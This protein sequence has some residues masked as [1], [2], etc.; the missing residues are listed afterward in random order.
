L[1]RQKLKYGAIMVK[2][3][4]KIQ[5]SKVYNKENDI[6]NNEWVQLLKNIKMVQ[7]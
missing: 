7:I 6:F 5:Q 2:Q 1:E 4:Y 3:T